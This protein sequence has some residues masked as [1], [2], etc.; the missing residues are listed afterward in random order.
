V[1]GGVGAPLLADRLRTG[2]IVVDEAE[3]MRSWPD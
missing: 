2:H 1:G 3:F